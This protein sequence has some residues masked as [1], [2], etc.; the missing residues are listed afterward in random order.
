[1]P[2]HVGQGRPA[3]SPRSLRPD[4]EVDLDAIANTGLKRK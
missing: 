1:L 4:D 3:P 2:L